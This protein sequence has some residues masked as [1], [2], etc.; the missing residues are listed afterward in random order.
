[1][2]KLFRLTLVGL[3]FPLLCGCGK[4]V[5]TDETSAANPN[6]AVL[7][8]LNE[9]RTT[10]YFSSNA[11]SVQD[12]TAIIEAGRNATSGRNMQPW[13]FSAIINQDVIKEI[14]AGMAV[15]PPTG[16]PPSAPAGAQGATASPS[17]SPQLPP[18]SS[19]YP[20]VGFATA[21]AAI[22]IACTPGD[23][24]SAGLASQNMFTAALLKGFGAKI[25]AG[26]AA[27]LNSDGN[28]AK[29]GIPAGMNIVA[30]LIVG[31]ADTTIDMTADGVTGASTRK[32][33]NEIATII[34]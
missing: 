17:P 24:F 29:L 27:A 22:A 26:G 21:P 19:A 6:E 31:I 12:I 8:M 4:V 1:M 25:V 34:E 23:E 33:F 16:A 5:S 18:S 2:Y 7:S 15:M 14:S 28:K 13:H 32:P 9:T 10:Q 11:M 30:I 20:K 3:L